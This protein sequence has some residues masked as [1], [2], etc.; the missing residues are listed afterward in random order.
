MS[1]KN[2]QYYK[3]RARRDKRQRDVARLMHRGLTIS[4]I[5]EA[6][7]KMGNLGKDEKPYSEAT[8]AKDVSGLKRTWRENAQKDTAGFMGK[9]KNMLEQV[10]EQ[11]LRDKDLEL[12]LK[13]H[14]RL[15]KLLGINA[16]ERRELSG[17]DGRPLEIKQEGNVLDVSKLSLDLRKRLAEELETTGSLTSMLDAVDAAGDDESDEEE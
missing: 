8:V 16:P 12:A 14:D 15:A 9:Q 17:P 1:G 3:Q 4:E 7:T 6:L 11:A 2:A 13:T 5:T 10:Q